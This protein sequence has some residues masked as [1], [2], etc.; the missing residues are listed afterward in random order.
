VGLLIA[1][2]GATILVCC[3]VVMAR[4]V[5]IGSPHV[6]A[7]TVRLLEHGERLLGEVARF[8]PGVGHRGA[9]RALAAETGTAEQAPTGALER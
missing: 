8:Q 3:I 4:L 9:H 7:A 2:V 1:A 5:G 6:S